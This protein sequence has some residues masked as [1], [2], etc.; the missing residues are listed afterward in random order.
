MPCVPELLPMP[1]EADDEEPQEEGV[2]EIGQEPVCP[3]HDPHHYHPRGCPYM[4]CPYPH[5]RALPS[6]TPCQPVEEPCAQPVSGKKKKIKKKPATSGSVWKKVLWFDF[7]EVFGPVGL[8]T[9]EFRPTDDPRYS[10][11]HRMPF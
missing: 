9:L 10:T 7:E 11:S 8:D 5:G 6:V 3:D 1:A 2:E 4:G